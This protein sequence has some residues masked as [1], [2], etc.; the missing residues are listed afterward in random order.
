[1]TFTDEDRHAGV[2]VRVKEH[3][4]ERLESLRLRNDGPLDAMETARL[5]GRI[6]EL[7]YLLDLDNP[8]PAISDNDA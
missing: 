2:W 3:M 8:G 6:N 5:R 4:L 7:K 1:M